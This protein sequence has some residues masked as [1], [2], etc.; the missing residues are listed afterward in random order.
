MIRD[1]KVRILLCGATFSGN[2]GGQA[3]YDAIIDELKSC[4]SDVVVSVLSKYPEDD[5]KG[6]EERGY[7]LIE[8]PTIKQLICGCAFFIVG[9]I[10]KKLHISYKWMLGKTFSAYAEND[11]LVDASGIA[12]TDDRS[13]PNILINSLWF[14]P[15]FITDIPIVKVSQTLG[16]YTKWYVNF[17]ARIVLKKIDI[18]VC[19]GQLS[20]NY[21]RDFLKQKNIYNLPD[22]A[23]GLKAI[24]G[25][26]AKII[27]SS[28][29]I[30]KGE[31]ITVGPSF[32]MRDFFE[33]GR[34]IE[35]VAEMVNKLSE[36]TE[37]TFVFVPHS[38]KHSDKVGVDSVN[39][40]YSVCTDIIRLLSPKVKVSVVEHEMSA[41]EFK[42]II[43]NSY[44]AI[45][46]RYHFLIAAL[47]SGVPSMALGWS[48]KYKELF[49]EFGIEDYVL[50]YQEMDKDNAY[51]LSKNLLNE[52]DGVYCKINFALPRVKEE[53]AKNVKLIIDCL[54]ENNKIID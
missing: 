39:D 28:L 41:R 10:L 27:L 31:Y 13:F 42:T 12:F 38:W 1:K 43:G 5:R 48:H 30:K 45:G 11:I 35:I 2:L 47:S 25:E 32:V 44:M 24:E 15:A 20:Y 16:P 53:A 19:R 3:M 29:G 34:Y 50:E 46:S 37:K 26:R 23:F 21:T 52:R 14:L 17:F 33:T 40:D 7:E 6:C 8:Y 51:E 4:V 36:N 22:T 49:R 9:S 54:R 18:I